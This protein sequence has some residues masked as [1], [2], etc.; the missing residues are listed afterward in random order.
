MNATPE[1]TLN[2]MIRHHFT[3]DSEVVAAEQNNAQQTFKT[4]TNRVNQQNNKRGQTG[5]SHLSLGATQSGGA[6][7]STECSH[8]KGV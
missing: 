5:K 1:E 8:A 2:V 6:G 7:Q 3:G 4:P